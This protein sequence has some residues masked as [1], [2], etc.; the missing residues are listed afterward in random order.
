MDIDDWRA[1]IDEIDLAVLKLLNKRAEY[2]VEIGDIKYDRDLPVYSPEREAWIV[3]RAA[4]ENPGPLTADAVRRIF[5]RIIDE[6]RK[7]EKDECA[8]RRKK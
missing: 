4:R 8:Q 1:K 5:E 2:S 7:L 6:S 3:E